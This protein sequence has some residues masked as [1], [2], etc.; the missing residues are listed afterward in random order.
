MTHVNYSWWEIGNA[1][2]FNP[3]EV[4]ASLEPP[5]TGYMCGRCKSLIFASGP[6]PC[7]GNG[8]QFAATEGNATDGE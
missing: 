8:S 1:H 3:M 2:T 5:R 4:P 7:C 6:C